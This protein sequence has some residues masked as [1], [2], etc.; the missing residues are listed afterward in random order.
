[1]TSTG[2]VGHWWTK[3]QTVV[4]EDL[5]VEGMIQSARGTR[6][7]SGTPVWSQTSLTTVDREALPLGTAMTY[8]PGSPMGLSP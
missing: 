6:E 2:S 8:E 4:G 7:Q 3:T 1:M 5:H